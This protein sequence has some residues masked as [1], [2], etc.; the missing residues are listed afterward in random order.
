MPGATTPQTITA[1]AD[2]C[3]QCGLCLPA[4]PTYSLERLEPQSPRGRIALARAWAL[5]IIDP[6]PA[7]DRHLDDCLAC[8]ACEAVCPA[9]VRYGE[10]LVRT[11]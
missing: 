4:C 11:R 3:V 2:R 1:L 8:R 9:G 10:L 6:T 5:D 7:G